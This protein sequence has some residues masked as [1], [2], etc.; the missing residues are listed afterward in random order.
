MKERREEL[1]CGKEG[2]SVLEEC[3]GGWD[4]EGERGNGKRV[5]KAMNMHPPNIRLGNNDSIY[6]QS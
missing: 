2:M 3:V 4:G 6:L 1:E 5:G